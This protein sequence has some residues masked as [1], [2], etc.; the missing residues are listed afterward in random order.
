LLQTQ[1][2]VAAAVD[3]SALLLWPGCSVSAASVEG[4]AGVT[5]V[6]PGAYVFGDLFLSE[7]TGVM[8]TDA[9]ALHVL[10]TVVDRPAPG[11]ALLDTGSKTLSSDKTAE[12]VFARSEWGD[13]TRV[14]EEHG[15]L[16]GPRV[17]EL[18]VGQ[19]LTLMPA[20]VCPVVNLADGVVVVRGDEVL[21]KWRV[22]ARGKT[23]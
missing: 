5:A 16:T 23:Q 9:V 10:A 12:G 7:I 21:D 2:A 14:S 4:I 22:D 1:A 8:K 19:R 15:F 17:D 11:L 6:R 20:H 18:R 3:N 13:V